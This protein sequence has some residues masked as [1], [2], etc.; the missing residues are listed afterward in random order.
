MYLDSTRIFSFLCI[1]TD[2]SE[3]AEPIGMILFVACG[4]YA[5]V[6]PVKKLCRFSH[7]KLFFFFF[8]QKNFYF[9]TDHIFHICPSISPKRLDQSR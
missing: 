5:P 2:F 6:G 7:R 9:C 4:A 3:V 8:F 1:F